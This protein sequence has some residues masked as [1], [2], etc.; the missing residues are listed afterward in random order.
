MEGL[1]AH[2]AASGEDVLFVQQH[3]LP[4]EFIEW[5]GRPDP[6]KPY[7]RLFSKAARARRTYF[8]VTNLRALAVV[9]GRHGDSVESA[10]IKL[11]SKVSTS[12]RDIRFGVPSTASWSHASKGFDLSVRAQ[13]TNALTFY[14]IEDPQSVAALVERL[15]AEGMVSDTRGV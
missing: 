11:I 14:D 6:G 3:L 1:V 2:T 5:V 9:R 10:F 13:V 7:R 12:E 15:R 8:A 4:D